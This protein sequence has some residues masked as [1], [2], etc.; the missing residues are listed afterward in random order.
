MLIAT[1]LSDK[2]GSWLITY[3]RLIPA[4]ASLG[5]DQSRIT[6][7]KW[8]EFKSDSQFPQFEAVGSYSLS[9]LNCSAT[10][11]GCVENSELH[12]YLLLADARF[13]I[14]CHD[15][16]NGITPDLSQWS[17][18]SCRVLSDSDSVCE[19]R[20]SCLTVLQPSRNREQTLL[21]YRDQLALK[22]FS[23]SNILSCDPPNPLAAFRFSNLPEPLKPKSIHGKVA[24]VSLPDDE[25]TDAATHVSHLIAVNIRTMDTSQPHP[26]RT[27]T[28]L[29]TL[30]LTRLS[31]ELAEYEMQLSSI[32]SEVHPVCFSVHPFKPWLA[33][34][35]TN[36]QASVFQAGRSLE[37]RIEL[38]SV[39][40]L[41]AVQSLPI[42]DRRA[43]HRGGKSRRGVQ[44]RSAD[45][46]SNPPVSKTNAGVVTTRLLALEFLTSAVETPDSNLE[47]VG[48][49]ETVIGREC[50]RRDLIVYGT[51]PGFKNQVSVKWTPKSNSNAGILR[52]VDPVPTG[53]LDVHPPIAGRKR[54][55]NQMDLTIENALRQVSQY[56]LMTAPAPEQLLHQLMSETPHP[57]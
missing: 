53:T 30:T 42:C 46:D 33:V 27:T 40:T 1:A 22:V 25:E 17:L 35:L 56:P 44:P 9:H 54:K 8:T 38:C 55:A 51:S 34:G 31:R 57:N 11:L 29:T 4:C 16:S 6:W 12:A 14:W 24:V 20:M 15:L 45:G 23:W 13:M 7:W 50:N 3:D 26:K 47:L 52:L 19:D 36:G 48:L 39:C 37:K 10:D 41:P 43:R 5:D 49:V 28:V 21:L 2:H 32:L 18:K